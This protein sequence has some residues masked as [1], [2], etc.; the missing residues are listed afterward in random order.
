M[1]VQPSPAGAPPVT[2]PRIL[3]GAFILWQLVFLFAVN[4]IELTNAVRG[5]LPTDSA[6]AIGR[7]FP[8]WP[9]KRGHFHDLLDI[10]ERITRR[11]AQA[12]GQTQGWSLFAPEVGKQCVF[13][14]VL[15]RWDEDPLSAPVLTRPLTPLAASTPL[16]SAALW[17]AVLGSPFPRPVPQQA[18]RS[19][20][21]LAA[22][23]PLEASILRAADSAGPPMALPPAPLTLL[24]DNEPRD[25]TSFVRIGKFRLRRLEGNLV[26]ILRQYEDETA[27]KAAKRWRRRI[28]DHLDRDGDTVTAYLRW[29][30]ES[31]RRA[32]PE[33][34]VP[35][36]LILVMRRRAIVP[37]EKAPP[38]WEGPFI[39]PVARLQP[40]V[41]WV[42]PRLPLEM[43]NPLTQR[44][45]EIKP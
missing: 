44:F 40:R 6:P 37:P 4:F 32:H 26:L 5:D 12:T 2:G 17:G 10:G 1:D 31:Y 23:S 20:A 30:W 27:L 16:Q 45:E 8:G 25:V 38:Y 35:A 34:P 3:L 18:A 13:P 14:A 33:T 29:R 36:Q 42:P 19:L 22:T 43:Y 41:H 28:Y 24:S 21:T 11:Y 7:V 9:S 15:V 39:V